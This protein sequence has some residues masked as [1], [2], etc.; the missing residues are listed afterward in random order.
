MAV[1]IPASNTNDWRQYWNEDSNGQP[2]DPKNENS[3]R[4]ALLSDLKERLPE[5]VDAQPEGRYA[6]EGRADI[7]VSHQDFNVPVEVKKNSHPN[8]WSAP[9]QQ[10]VARYA[11]DPATG[12]Y[13]IYLV[14]W[15]GK[16]RT[17][18]SPDGPRPTTPEQLREQ[19]QNTLTPEENRKITVCVIDVGKP[20]RSKRRSGR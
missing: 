6:Y 7:R 1:R 18:P 10:L 5:G 3:C 17:Q 14:F 20:D 13:G 2:E 15:F 16:E 9:R 8:L 19:L 4:D 11:S 12:G